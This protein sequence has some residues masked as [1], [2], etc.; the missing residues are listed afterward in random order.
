MPV[1]TT[2]IGLD[3]QHNGFAP[4]KELIPVIQYKGEPISL[5][6]DFE[7]EQKLTLTVDQTAVILTTQQ[8]DYLI[9][10]NKL[11]RILDFAPLAVNVYNAIKYIT[12]HVA[13]QNHYIT[14]DLFLSNHDSEHPYQY[15]KLKEKMAFA[16]CRTS[17]LATDTFLIQT[18]TQFQEAIALFQIQKENLWI[19]T[20][21]KETVQSSCNRYYEIYFDNQQIFPMKTGPFQCTRLHNSTTIIKEGDIN[22]NLG[23]SYQWWSGSTKQYH[24]Y[25]TLRLSI[26]ADKNNICTIHQPGLAKQQV[27]NLDTCICVKSGWDTDKKHNDLNLQVVLRKLKRKGIHM[28]HFRISARANQSQELYVRQAPTKQGNKYKLIIE[29]YSSQEVSAWALGKYIEYKNV[30]NLDIPLQTPYGHTDKLVQA[31]LP[32]VLK[33]AAK[34]VLSTVGKRFV[35][36]VIAKT[37]D[38]IQQNDEFGNDTDLHMVKNHKIDYKSPDKI[39]VAPKHLYSAK[40]WQTLAQNLS[41]EAALQAYYMALNTLLDLSHFQETAIPFLIKNFPKFKPNIVPTQFKIAN[42]IPALIIDNAAG[43]YLAQEIFL[44]TYDPED[45]FNTYQFTS[46]PKNEI[47]NRFVTYDLPKNLSYKNGKIF[48]QNESK[49]SQRQYTCVTNLLEK[50]F[51]NMKKNCMTK[52]VE[53]PATK[54]LEQNDFFSIYSIQAKTTIQLA[55]ENTHTAFYKLHKDVN[56]ILLAHGCALHSLDAE[57]ALFVPRHQPQNLIFREGIK[58][59]IQYDLNEKYSYLT[60]IVIYTSATISSVVLILGMALFGLAIYMK[61]INRSFLHMILPSIFKSSINTQVDQE[62]D[63]PVEIQTAPP[64]SPH[65][66]RF[67]RVKNIFQ[68]KSEDQCLCFCHDC[69]TKKKHEKGNCNCPFALTTQMESALESIQ[70]F[71]PDKDNNGQKDTPPIKLEGETLH[72]TP[73][74]PR[75]PVVH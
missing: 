15:K 32:V 38:L 66:Q 61:R 42:D 58:L 33:T 44:P 54:L 56:I 74:R 63:S 73:K 4:P 7:I 37:K 70:D 5:T 28:D 29:P 55:C 8:K 10:W 46:I 47:E 50:D 59:L 22:N 65:K 57:K 69:Q 40:Q 12:Q 16:D 31:I 3:Q 62:L 9:N 20:F 41:K 64:N 25:G 14:N 23:C 13:T 17:C 67:D 36:S 48:F 72:S 35:K 6:L 71:I 30:M 43:S 49:N 51:H 26:S 24:V 11:T 52:N 75:N 60:N 45:V 34:A 39:K 68:S 27:S 1:N 18:K 19:K 21:S 2:E 53:I